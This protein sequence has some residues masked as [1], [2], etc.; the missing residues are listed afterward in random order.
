METIKTLRFKLETPMITTQQQSEADSNY[1]LD[2]MHRGEQLPD[3]KFN[4][5]RTIADMV[6]YMVHNND[7]FMIED[8]KADV[9]YD[10]FCDADKPSVIAEKR[11]VTL[12]QVNQIVLRHKK[13]AI[14]LLNNQIKQSDLKRLEDTIE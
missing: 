1:N 8:N 2:S 3:Y 5:N 12:K 11:N 13:K 9:L 7:S 10:Y 6:R 4:D 14:K